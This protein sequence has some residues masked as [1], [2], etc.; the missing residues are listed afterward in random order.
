MNHLHWLR[1]TASAAGSKASHG[2]EWKAMGLIIPGIVF[3]AIDT[4]IMKKM[5][6]I[7]AYNL[8]HQNQTSSRTIESRS[9]Y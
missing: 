2:A 5:A 1:S 3:P 8:R 6:T 9:L 7:P 4:S